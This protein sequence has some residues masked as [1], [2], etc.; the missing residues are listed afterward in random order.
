MKSEPR[1]LLRE[2]AFVTAGQAIAAIGTLAGIRL[3]TEV[4]PPALFGEFSLAMGVLSLVQGLAYQPFGQAVLRYY[5]D[6]INNVGSETSLRRRLAGTYARRFVA[7]SLGTVAAALLPM[8]FSKTSS[9]TVTLFLLL[10]ALEGWK[11]L[12]I[13]LA[14]ASRHQ[15]VYASLLAADAVLRPLASVG[16]VLASEPSVEALVAGQCLALAV[17]LGAFHVWRAK[18]LH[19]VSSW[20]IEAQLAAGMKRFARPLLWLPFIGWMSGLADR[21][22][23]GGMLGL[24][25]AG[26]YAAAYGLASRPFLFLGT[27]TEATMRQP[28]Y[29]AFSNPHSQDGKRLL[30]SWVAI[31]LGIGSVGAFLIW[32]L[33]DPLAALLLAAPYRGATGL[34]AW[35]AGGYVL[36]LV[37]Q[38][39]ERMIYVAGNTRTVVRIQFVS[40]SVGVILACVAAQT[41]GLKG[42]AAA[43]PIYFG[44]QMVM[45]L[46]AAKR[47][48][49]QA[50][51][52]PDVVLAKERT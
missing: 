3:L 37:A 25:A 47:G 34:L 42:V 50:A 44:L 27:I 29:M 52:P 20:A 28:V 31:N 17:V 46:W 24:E 12:E 36:L 48:A 8:H 33:R 11:A 21:Y 15:S 2:G 5:F 16:V 9:L 14:N 13:V 19:A 4:A 18:P 1:R 6:W 10:F 7:F 40:A 23:V 45:T 38:G 30:A 39:V 26:I 35:I 51:S 22:I 32:W 43:V 49:I 41:M